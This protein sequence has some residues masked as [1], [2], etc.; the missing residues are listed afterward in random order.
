[1]RNAGRA[2]EHLL[3]ANA[4]VGLLIAAAA[5]SGCRGSARRAADGH[6]EAD[7]GPPSEVVALLRDLAAKEDAYRAEFAT[8]LSTGT[9]G[10][11]WPSEIPRT[12]IEVDDS[13][14][15]Q[16]LKELGFRPLAKVWCGYVVVAG[17]AG[18]A[19]GMGPI[20]RRVFRD[21]IPE[22]DWYYVVG[23]CDQDGNPEVDTVCALSSASAAL[24][25]TDIGR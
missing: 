3:F 18:S 16:K 8:Y 12:G 22:D 17:P 14:V 6:G 11:Y 21:A 19:E 20:G 23:R 24:E 5:W 10:T 15:P 2:R 7:A 4:L 13:S 25:C 1:M 9:E